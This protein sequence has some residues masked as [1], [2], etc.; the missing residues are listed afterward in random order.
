MSTRRHGGSLLRKLLLCC[1]AVL[2]AL[3]V[4][5]F[6]GYGQLL[7]YL[8]GESFRDALEKVL[9]SKTQATATIDG[10]L[11]ID[12][13]R[14]SLKGLKLERKSLPQGLEARNIHAELVRS[15]LLDKELRLT[16]LMV[17]EGALSL[18]LD[19]RRNKGGKGR[20]KN[21]RRA[22]S[23]LSELAPTHARL[24]SFDCEDFNAAIRYKEQDYRLVDSSLSANPA[25]QATASAR[26][27]E[28]RFTGG[29]LHTP[30]PITGNS[31]LK[32]ANLLYGGKVTSLSDAR[33]MLSPGELIVNALH[34]PASGNWSADIRG[35]SVELSRLIGE[36]WKKR[37]SGMLY[38]RIHAEGDAEG[39]QQAEGRISLQQ[40]VLEAMPFLSNLPVGDS[41]PYRS[42]KLEKATARLSFPHAD[43][44]RNI[45]RAWLLD[46]IDLRAEGGW[47]RV[48]GHALVDTDG[49]LSG[50]L[51]IGLP[52]TLA[53][54]LAPVKSPL[55]RSIFN[56]E[57]E[58][59]YL[60]LRMNLSGSLKAPQE[61]LSVRLRTLIGSALPD[62]AGALKDLLL[63]AGETQ[64][65][66]ESPTPA[67]QPGQLLQEAGNA[68]GQ[69]INTGL[70]AFF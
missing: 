51:L 49:T 59:G 14:I 58:A 63:P 43:A 65:A 10:T 33:L 39:L 40:G 26:P 23:F 45:S 25:G 18:N 7:S 69:L 62:A 32:S 17:E 37:V 27:W 6:I 38:G 11:E 24:D 52:E 57:G 66:A 13:N 20:T 34:E 22:E 8:Q 12:A 42:L 47:L 61:D 35:N 29:R 54:R 15:A 19:T 9:A 1:A 4:L 68:A 70:R 5:L 60:W 41:Y 64:P 67:P 46:E 16:R 48:R 50:T 44:A 28:L 21:S 53:I 36:D 31:S 3:L 56:A 30:L 55:H 2:I